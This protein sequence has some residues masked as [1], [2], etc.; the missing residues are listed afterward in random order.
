[1]LKPLQGNEFIKARKLATL[2]LTGNK[3]VV[4]SNVPIVQ[5]LKLKTLNLANCSITQL[6]DNIFQNLSSLVALYLENNPLESV[7]YDFKFDRPHIWFLKANL[8]FLQALNVKA[9]KY[10]ENLRTLNMPTVSRDI[11]S[12]LCA[13]ID[14]IDIIHLTQEKYDISC[15]ILTSGSTFDESTI[16]YGQSTL[17]SADIESNGKYIQI[18]NISFQTM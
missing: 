8:C 4:T 5:N 1:M 12:D 6:S 9:F 7:R 11:V 3:N 14:S 10:L 17:S 15:F 13:A 16:I 18:S 2:L